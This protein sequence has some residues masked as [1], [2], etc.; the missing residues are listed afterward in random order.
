MP[1]FFIRS[2]FAEA[3]FL[4]RKPLYSI[5]AKLLGPVSELRDHT[6]G[7]MAHFFAKNPKTEFMLDKLNYLWENG[8]K[9]EEV[10]S[11]GKY[12]VEYLISYLEKKIKFVEEYNGV[13]D[14]A[15]VNSY[16]GRSF[17]HM[18]EKEVLC[19]KNIL[20]CIGSMLPS[21]EFMQKKGIDTRMKQVSELL[22]NVVKFEEKYYGFIMEQQTSKKEI[23]NVLVHDEPNVSPKAKKR[24]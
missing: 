18:G 19:I 23:E 15:R 13:F 5:T 17:G 9:K 2:T 1:N 3:D 6:K 24:L 20:D 11:Y 10:D 4:I 7:T 16:S 8:V 21:Y 14:E 22:N 12:A